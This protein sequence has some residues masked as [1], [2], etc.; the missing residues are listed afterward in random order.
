MAIQQ[1][2]DIEPEE[3]EVVL[4]KIADRLHNLQTI[5]AGKDR[6]FKSLYYGE[7]RVLCGVL[8]PLARKHGW[9]GPLASLE[10]EIEDLGKYVGCINE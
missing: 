3:P 8:A 5:Y 2:V 10:R 1:I 7:S 9:D 6:V 4:I